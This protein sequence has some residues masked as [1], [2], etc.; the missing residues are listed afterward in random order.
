MG[1]IKRFMESP[2]TWKQ[3]TIMSLISFLITGA[4]YIYVSADIWGSYLKDHMKP[5]KKKR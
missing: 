1:K 2:I 3:I 4:A 5:K